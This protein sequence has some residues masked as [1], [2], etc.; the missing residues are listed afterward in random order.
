AAAILRLEQQGRLRV[1]DRL[2]AWLGPLPAPKDQVTLHDLLVHAGGL[3]PLSHPVFEERSED[4]IAGLRSTPA[5]FAP[6]QA[7]RHTD[8]GYSALA[9][10]VERASGMP[11]ETFVRRELLVPAGMQ[12]TWF[13]SEAPPPHTAI[14]YSDTFDPRSAVG[15]RPYVWGRRGAMGIVSTVE[16]LYRW[17]RALEQG[18]FPPDVPERM[19]SAG[20][21]NPWRSIT[22]YGWATRRT[23]RGTTVHQLLSGWPGNSVELMHDPAKRITVALMMDNRV[24]WVHPRHDAIVRIALTGDPDGSAQSHLQRTIR[25]W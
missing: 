11:Y 15:Q 12:N 13:D 10:V 17:H 22:G 5:E 6:G 24:D 19:Y 4:F 18:L 23:G 25:N 1:S 9:L 7:Q 2:T 3:T 8:I 14:E 16:D 21:V 20:I